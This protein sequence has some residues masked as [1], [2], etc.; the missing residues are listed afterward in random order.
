[1][2]KLTPSEYEKVSP[3]FQGLDY[4]LITSAVLCGA[5][6]G[7]I[8]V[9]ST[10]Q[11]R[12][13]FMAS[14]EGYFLAGYQHND[15]FNH[16]LNELI[17]G[18]V[19]P[20]EKSAQFDDALVVV[21]HPGTWEHQFDVVLAGRPPIKRRRIHYLFAKKQVEWKVRAP[22]GMTVE[23]ID[24]RLLS[25]PGLSIPEHVMGWM[26]D[27]WGSV[28]GFLQKGFGFCTVHA[29]RIVSWSLADCIAGDACEIG[30]HTAK[31]YR[32]RG[33]AT[34]TAT[35][36]V[37]YALARG[38]TAVGWH[39][40]EDNLGSQGVAEK[41]GFEKER[42]YFEYLVITDEVEHLASHGWY[43][44]RTEKYR[45]AIRWFEQ[46]FAAGEPPNWSFHTAA[47]AWAV[48]GDRDAAL[49]YLA[50]AVDRGWHNA[51]FTQSCKEFE[52]LHNAPEWDG[53]LA[54][55]EAGA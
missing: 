10:R 3:L 2:Y 5:S 52:P 8:W 15:A 53:L 37:D 6:P 22:S 23:R 30:I 16:A 48:L 38:L 44:F 12:S 27:N 45:E 20:D 26:E 13:A 18:D 47:Q 43:S 46:A 32:R 29:D 11:P 14:P 31:E 25:R 50:R 28:D 51:T 49:Q 4:Q 41:V 55:M 42:G 54:R 33:L 24:E 40:N 35:A 39:C 9:D 17:L 1:M 21:C 36:A 7:K 19:L 34:L